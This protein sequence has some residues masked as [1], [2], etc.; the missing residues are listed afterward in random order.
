MGSGC[1]P[2]RKEDGDGKRLLQVADDLKAILNEWYESVYSGESGGNQY[3]NAARDGGSLARL[4]V[5]ES[6]IRGE[7]R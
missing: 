3:D 4:G 2:L 6:L 5:A 1:F 7:V